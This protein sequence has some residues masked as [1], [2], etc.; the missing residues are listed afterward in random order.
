MDIVTCK[1]LFLVTA[2]QN[3]V[4]LC[5]YDTI[6]VLAIVVLHLSLLNEFREI[7]DDHNAV[8]QVMDTFS[9]IHS[10]NS[11]SGGKILLVHETY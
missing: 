5:A 8:A 7:P 3:L 6:C 4:A 1:G 10:H 9:I 11:T 2:R